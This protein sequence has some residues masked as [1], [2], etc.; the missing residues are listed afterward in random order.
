MGLEIGD[1]VEGI[2]CGNG[3]DKVRGI[4]TA[5]VDDK[6]RID[7]GIGRSCLCVS[8]RKISERELNPSMLWWF[9]KRRYELKGEVDADQGDNSI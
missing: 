5:L 4:L 1:F 6:V 2:Y 3:E 9:R 8:P 7:L